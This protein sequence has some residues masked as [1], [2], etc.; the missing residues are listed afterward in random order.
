MKAKS[1]INAAGELF[2]S[3][4]VA[5]LTSVV[6]ALVLAGVLTFFDLSDTVV[7]IVVTAIKVLSVLL[8]IVIGVRSGKRGAIKGIAVAVIY[9]A[10]CYLCASL[11]LGSFE[12]SR[13]FLIDC[14]VLLFTSLIGGVIVVNRK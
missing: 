11:S 1:Q 10:V 14:A 8:G 9:A 12:P 3:T 5:V 4:S 13:S 7:D 2:L 6:L